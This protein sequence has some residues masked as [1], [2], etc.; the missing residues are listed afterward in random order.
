[1]LD[2][3]DSSERRQPSQAINGVTPINGAK[4]M[5][6]EDVLKY[7]RDLHSDVQECLCALRV[8]ED[9]KL[10]SKFPPA[11][12]KELIEL[13]HRMSTH[14]LASVLDKLNSDHQNISIDG[15]I[16]AP[17]LVE[18]I[19]CDDIDFPIPAALLPEKT[20]NKKK[21]DELAVIMANVKQMPITNNVIDPMTY[22]DMAT[23]PDQSGHVRIMGSR[24][25]SVTF[26]PITKEEFY[27][28]TAG[29]VDN[30]Q[31]NVNLMKKEADKRKYDQERAEQKIKD[32]IIERGGE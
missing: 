6:K 27:K 32:G 7:I 10:R 31:S 20:W 8:L 26:R 3:D 18:F 25:G 30:F 4:I 13:N 16:K 1:M 5:P 12:A 23:N 22:I 24:D 28:K 11:N 19:R 14:P 17:S 2:L 29:E 21:L 15:A 9:L